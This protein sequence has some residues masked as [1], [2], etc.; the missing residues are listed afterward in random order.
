MCFVSHQTGDLVHG[1]KGVR[2]LEIVQD[3]YH[4]IE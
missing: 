2:L 4:E 3:S 1:K